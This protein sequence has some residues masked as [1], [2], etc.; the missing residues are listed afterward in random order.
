[1]QPL[2]LV[3]GEEEGLV[4]A[5]GTTDGTAKLILLEGRLLPVEE[6]AGIEFLVAQE[7][8]RRAMNLVG[9]GAGDHVDYRAAGGELRVGVGHLNFELADALQVGKDLDR[10]HHLVAVVEAVDHEQIEAA[11][12]AG[13]GDLSA[14]TLGLVAALGLANTAHRPRRRTRHQQCEL[15]E[16]SAIQRELIDRGLVNY[17]AHL[18]RLGVE[19]RRAHPRHSPAAGRRPP[20]V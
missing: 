19:Q 15:R 6:P 16:V 8:E 4:L 5:Y 17:V 3:I 18:H 2:P 12:R 10:A 9:A 7:L 14:V 20:A 11:A 13:R 1:M